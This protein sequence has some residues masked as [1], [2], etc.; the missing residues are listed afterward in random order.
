MFQLLLRLHSERDVTSRRIKKNLKSSTHHLPLH[1][2]LADCDSADDATRGSIPPHGQRN[3][4]LDE[5][6]RYRHPNMRWFLRAYVRVCLAHGATQLSHVKSTISFSGLVAKYLG[7][8]FAHALLKVCIAIAVDVTR[9]RS[10]NGV[11][12]TED[13]SAQRD[14]KYTP[15]IALIPART[16]H[17][18]HQIILISVAH[19]VQN[20][21]RHRNL[22][23][24]SSLQAVHVQI[25]THNIG[26]GLGI[27]SR[28]RTANVYLQ[29]K[30]T[31]SI[32]LQ[33]KFK[34]IRP[35]LSSSNTLEQNKKKPC[36]ARK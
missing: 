33:L 35:A 19:L 36:H 10:A 7:L 32:L 20:V 16:N 1:A 8:L 6:L 14:T 34:R 30:T 27:R 31:Y 24:L 4:I 13:A 25:H 5:F 21:C 17:A 15:T 26:D 18:R 2:V 12:L 29:K 11:R 9:P 3:C 22:R 23:G 28:A